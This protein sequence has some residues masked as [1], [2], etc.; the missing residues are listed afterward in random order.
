MQRSELTT[1]K[2]RRSIAGG[3]HRQVRQ[4]ER[5]YRGGTQTDLRGVLL[6][7]DIEACHA[8]ISNEE[9]HT[10]SRQRT[11][12]ANSLVKTPSVVQFENEHTYP[13]A[14][15]GVLLIQRFQGQRKESSDT[16]W[17]DK[18]DRSS[19]SQ[20]GVRHATA[21]SAFETSGR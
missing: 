18:L 16:W 20:F 12:T 9:R 3:S 17:P 5:P 19:Q 2:T 13:C 4:D 7:M 6:R 10:R 15:Q 1:G 11:G 8:K 14:L 21:A